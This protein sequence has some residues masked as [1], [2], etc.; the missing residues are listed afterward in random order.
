MEAAGHEAV[1]RVE[2]VPEVVASG[3]HDLF[4]AASDELGLVRF[5]HVGHALNQASNGNGIGSEASAG[6]NNNVHS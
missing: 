3:V 1:A 2:A 5:G 4:Q 6:A